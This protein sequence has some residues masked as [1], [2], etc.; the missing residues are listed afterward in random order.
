MPTWLTT[1]PQAVAT[2]LKLS[3]AMLTGTW[4]KHAYV[5]LKQKLFEED[6]ARRNMYLASMAD[7]A[8]LGL[9]REYAGRNLSPS[10]IYDAVRYRIYRAVVAH[11][12]LLCVRPTRDQIS[13]AGAAHTGAQHLVGAC[14]AADRGR[15]GGGAGGVTTR[16]GGAS[17]DVVL[18][19]TW[20]FLRRGGIVSYHVSRPA[21]PIRGY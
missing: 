14:A 13:A 3:S 17:D 5:T 20:N 2:T 11:E 9:A 19:G 15:P 16:R 12:A 21:G 7:D 10:E 8:L 18:R 1:Q 4:L 6:A